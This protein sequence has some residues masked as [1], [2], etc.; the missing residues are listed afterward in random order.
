MTPA[1]CR[2][3]IRQ[4]RTTKSL[5][6]DA[7][8]RAYN[9]PMRRL[10]APFSIQLLD[11]V[12]STNDSILEAGAAGAPEGTTH[13]A[14]EQTHGRGR[15]DHTW[16]SPAGAGLW[17]STLLRPDCARGNWSGLSLLSGVAVRRA[18]AGLGVRGAELFWPNDIYVGSRKLGGILAEV[19]GRGQDA[20]VALGIGVN[21]DLTASDIVASMPEDLREQVICMTEAGPPT[22]RSPRDIAVAILESLAPS[23][24][25]FLDGEP[26]P[27]L[28]GDEMAHR[29][30]RVKVVR[31]ERPTMQGVVTGLGGSGELLVESS[32]GAVHSIIAAEVIYEH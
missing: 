15:G 24:R 19:R 9:A 11:R 4:T 31:P 8:H 3:A 27:S 5:P 20:W 12:T 6:G 23:Y 17:M 25:A 30:R 26:L 22:S 14:L 2:V 29:G 7:R 10:G 18:L 21:I 1:V 13:V 28:I 32:D 16:W